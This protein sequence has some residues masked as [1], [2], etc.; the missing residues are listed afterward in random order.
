MAR[1]TKRSVE[2]LKPAAKDY[3][4]WDDELAGF[5]VRVMRSGL[6]SYVLQYRTGGRTRRHAFSRVG[7]MTPDEAR[8]HAREQLVAVDK[9]QDPVADIVDYRRAPTVSDLCQRFLSE[10]VEL[11][12]KPTTQA[13]YKRSVNLFIKPRFG[14]FKVV[15][16]KRPDIAK[17]HHDMRATPYQANRTLGVVSKLFNLAEIWGLRPDGSNPCRHVAKYRETK[18]E[19]YLTFDELKRLGQV[20]TDIESDGSEAKPVINCIRLLML[21]GARLREIQTLKWEYVRDGFLALPDS[22]TGPKRIVLGKEATELLKQIV[23]IEGNPYVVTGTV[24]GQHWN[25]MQHPWR[26]IRSKAKLPDLRIHDLRHT[27]ASVAASQGESLAMIGKLLGHTQ[28]QTTARYAHLAPHP[29]SATADRIAAV[30]AAAMASASTG[31]HPANTNAPPS[32]E[33]AE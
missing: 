32:H 22:K 33:A 1:I 14:S 28:V 26:R 17:L 13:E 24:E 15:D 29:V 25:D 27:F 11:R 3:F 4:I 31:S 12:C 20:L 23:K 16:V 7:T 30:I 2:S 18:R 6:K 9:G 8:A 5:G 21:T 19:R 10:H